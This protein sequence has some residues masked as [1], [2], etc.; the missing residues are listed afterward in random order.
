MNVNLQ[1]FWTVQQASGLESEIFTSYAAAQRQV[2]EWNARLDAEF[3]Q[4]KKVIE[5]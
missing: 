4:W 5:T 1:D 2:N 3:E